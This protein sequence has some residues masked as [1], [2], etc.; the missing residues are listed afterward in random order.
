MR[1][2]ID[3]ALVFA[4]ACGLA[5]AQGGS[6]SFSRLANP[7]KVPQ[8]PPVSLQNSQ[9]IFDLMHAGQLY[10]S[11]DDAIALALENN[12][13][14][15]LER[16]LP[17]MA[18]TD[19]LRAHGGGLLRGLNLL[20]NETP[21]GIGGPN[22]PLLTNLTAGST[23]SALVNSNF[24]DIAL[25][26]QQ[27]NSL[28]VT[29][30]TPMANGS[31]IPQYD[32]IVTGLVNGQHLSIPEY[33][34][35]LSGSNWLAQNQVN[36]TAGVNVGF[37]S[38]AQ[39][40]VSFDNSRYSTDATR[41]TYNPIVNSSLG[42]TIT[43]P[44][45][46]GF[47]AGLNKRFIRIARNSQKVADLV[48]RQQ[49]M[50]TVSGVARLYT[51][52]VSLNEDVKVK[53]EALR[54]AERLYEDNKNQ[55]DQGTQAPIEVTRANAAV[56]VSRQALITSE[57]L[58]R[59]QELILKTAITR[60]GLANPLVLAAHIIPTDIQTVP[61]QQ[62]V[63]PLSDLVDEALKNRPDLAGA[64]LQVENSEI[65][66]QGSL[67][68]VKPQLDVVGTAQNSGMAG[69]LNPLAG[70]ATGGVTPG[71]YGTVLGQL[72]KRNYPSYGIGLQLTL[73]LRN[74]VAQADAVRDELQ[75]RQAQVRRQQL[76]DQV[77]LE[78]A[79]AEESVRQAQ[80]SYDAAVEARRLQEQSVNVEQQTFNVGLSTNLTVIQYENYL[81]QARST[82]VASKGAY[83][84]AQIALERATGAI[85]DIYHVA[86]DE[87]YKGKVA[88]PPS[89][90]PGS[91]R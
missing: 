76:L 64:S 21:P 85:L 2:P 56:A 30:A 71:G 40:G 66:L 50:D 32:P 3:K 63:Q 31:A 9:R 67:N 65:S 47:G 19:L 84:K 37:A 79:D 11:L 12:L 43:Q 70:A 54:L 52:L 73:P 13:D 35:L 59:Q 55:V 45:L 41:Y 61:D 8:A 23:P 46:Q 75:V 82:E 18:D 42:F 48:F 80:A 88:R 26:S 7:Y 91:A 83:I 25:I 89:A 57:G 33:S 4:A 34:T 87:A 69:N 53:Q 28:S 36:A 15:E 22:G 51:D 10:L 58:V 5:L 86:I 62:P 72:F 29:D 44:L 14:I 1:L 24:S 78:V 39:L 49:V 68:A 90:I 77:R 38:G 17:K 81:A 60:G 6:S 27:Q 16:V 20:V 74:R